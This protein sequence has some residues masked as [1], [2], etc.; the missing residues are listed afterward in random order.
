MKALVVYLR[1]L[2]ALGEGDRAIAIPRS[3]LPEELRADPALKPVEA[4]TS[5]MKQSASVGDVA[6][7]QRRLKENP[8]DNQARFDLALAS[9]DEQGSC[10]IFFSTS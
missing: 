6:G 4:A 7:L 10:Q 5:M 1:A 3:G 2:L 8:Q 9:L